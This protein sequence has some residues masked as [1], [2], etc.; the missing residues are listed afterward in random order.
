M[1][2]RGQDWVPID[3]FP[4]ATQQNAVRDLEK[5]FIDVPAHERKRDRLYNAMMQWGYGM[6]KPVGAFYL[7]GKAS[8]GDALAFTAALAERRST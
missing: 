8:G 6:T 3:A 1:R 2:I 7:W 4:D 5:V